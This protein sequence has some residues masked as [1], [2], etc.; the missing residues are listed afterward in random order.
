MLFR[1]LFLLFR[2]FHFYLQPFF[3]SLGLPDRTNPP[4]F[5]LV[6]VEVFIVSKS[7][8]SGLT[9]AASLSISIFFPIC[10]CIYLFLQISKIFLLLMPAANLLPHLILILGSSLSG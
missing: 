6:G 4:F 9:L 2:I 10:L 8:S 1:N 5:I 3:A 7:K